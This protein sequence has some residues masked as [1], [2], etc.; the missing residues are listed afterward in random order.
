M[1]EKNEWRDKVQETWKQLANSE[2]AEENFYH[3]RTLSALFDVEKRTIM[4]REKKEVQK[5]VL[6]EEGFF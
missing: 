3:A 2:P 5:I 6:D 1:N 4:E